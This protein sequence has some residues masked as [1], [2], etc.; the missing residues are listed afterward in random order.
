MKKLICMTAAIA[1]GVAMAEGI[2]SGIVGYF[3]NDMTGKQMNCVS[4][5]FATVGKGNVFTM[6]DIT[7]VSF[8]DSGD[9]LQFLEPVRAR[10]EKTY[11][12]WEGNWYEDT[13]DWNDANDDQ[14]DIGTG[15]LGNFTSKKV[16]L[17]SAG[18]VIE[19][20][21]A[22]DFTGKQIVMLG[23]PL[24][25]TV[26]FKEIEPVSFSDSG[27]ILQ[28]LEATRARTVKTYFAWEGDWYEDTSD[29][30]D[31]SEEEIASGE[32]LLGNFTSKKVKL[33]FPSAL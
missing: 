19:G 27:D 7:P 5:G 22:F 33:T 9:I 16:Q 14:F 3:N 23:N 2:S 21:T 13:T 25:R 26:K 30:N 17:T 15:F 24:P 20:A 11:F 18:E 28:R 12:A 6:K 32:A 4:C 31:A 29:W 10:T 8:S 1:A